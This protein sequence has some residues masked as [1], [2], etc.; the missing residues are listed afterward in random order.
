MSHFTVTVLLPADARSSVGEHLNRVLE[1]YNENREVEPYT[2]EDGGKTTYN[3][4]S[5]WDWWQIGGRWRGYFLPKANVDRRQLIFGDAGSFGNPADLHEGVTRPDGGH[6]SD[7]DLEAMRREKV[8]KAEAD[9]NAYA[10]VIH[11]TPEPLPWSHFYEQFE[12]ATGA[13]PTSRVAAIYAAENEVNRRYGLPEEIPYDDIPPEL[14]YDADGDGD[15]PYW[16]ELERA[17]AALQ[18]S[19]PETFARWEAEKKAAVE[20]AGQTWD[21]GLSYSMNHARA[22]YGAQPRVRAVRESTQYKDWFD[23]PISIFD[24]LTRD[25]YV[26]QQRDRAVPGYA[27]V[28]QDGEWLAPGSMGWFGMSSHDDTS[29]EMYARMVNKMID[30]LPGDTIIVALD[31]HI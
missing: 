12:G 29:Y 21:A 2:D 20:T 4:E 15:G 26:Q 28:T 31:C 13:M 27:T 22:D 3:P 11:G 6:L 10:M 14:K 9:W 24:H 8:V 1:R 18:A 7:L 17:R 25:E 19:D 5:K 16:I 23:D 30:G